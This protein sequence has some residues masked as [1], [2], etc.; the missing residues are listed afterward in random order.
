MARRATK[1]M[2]WKVWIMLVVVLGIVLY[3]WNERRSVY[4]I[5]A[6]V[7]NRIVKHKKNRYQI[8]E[9]YDVLSP[10]ECKQVIEFARQKGVEDSEVMSNT[11]EKDTEKDENWRR[12]RQ[13][14]ASEEE[15]PVLQKFAKFNEDL[16]GYRASQQE[17]AQ[18]ASYV[19]G[20]LFKEHYDACAF[21]DTEY[22][23][24]MNRDS[25]ERR[26]TLLLY[27]N[28]DFTG[29]E[30]EFTKMG[31]KIRPEVGKAVLFWDTYQDDS[32]IEQSMHQGN[33]VLTGEK[34]ILTKWS[35]PKHFRSV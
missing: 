29:G 23:N 17:E 32:I 2:G 33:I 7:P 19:P 35:H 26:T 13:V 15:H 1:S 11:H 12:S 31:I 4:W 22:C 16:T 3:A 28:T 24:R 14:W 27:L 34:W 5:P 25:G 18:I 10:E 30:T 20:G 6:K 21:D 9:I 8:W